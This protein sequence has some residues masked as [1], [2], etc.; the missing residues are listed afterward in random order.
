MSRSAFFESTTDD[1]DID[2][3]Y[4]QYKRYRIAVSWSCPQHYV[5][6]TFWLRNS[7]TI[8]E[9]KIARFSGV[10]KLPIFKFKHSPLF[11]IVSLKC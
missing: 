7:K 3:V 2:V 11:G 8:F 10:I 1:K 6:R 4:S 5:I 9:S